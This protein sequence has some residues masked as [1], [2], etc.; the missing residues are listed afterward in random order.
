[1]P[2]TLSKPGFLSSRTGSARIKLSTEDTRISDVSR[3]VNSLDRCTGVDS[4]VLDLSD[5]THL[6][7]TGL[8][9][10]AAWCQA[11]HIRPEVVN[12]DNVTLAYLEDIGFFD[13]VEGRSHFSAA[14]DE[15]WRV[16]FAPILQDSRPETI[17][18]N[19]VSICDERGF[20][21]GGD[22]NALVIA[23][24]EVIENVK[25]HAGLPCNG[26]VTAQFYPKR[27]EVTAIVVDTGMGIERSFAQGDNA[28]ARQRIRNGEDPL[29]LASSPLVTSKTRAHSGYGLYIVREATVLNGG[30]FR[31][32][33]GGRSLMLWRKHAQ[34][35]SKEERHAH[36]RG[37][38]VCMLFH[39]DNLF[40][41]REVFESLPGSGDSEIESTFEA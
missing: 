20:I 23:F 27:R 40:P 35:H 22:R 18:A 6:Y 41:M 17:A 15:G 25:R 2:T 33:S 10:V 16:A 9:L 37:T 11:K 31:I 4:L 19:F 13:A 30:T 7:V 36:W 28:D 24:S 38:A 8:A 34:R 39:L 1:V 12:A 3:L 26:L 32:T 29:W 21:G 5:V 14:R